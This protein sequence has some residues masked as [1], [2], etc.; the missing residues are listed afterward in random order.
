ELR[1]EPDVP[2][3]DPDHHQGRDG[4]RH[5]VYAGEGRRWRRD[6]KRRSPP[7]FR[8][9]GGQVVLC[10]SS[11]DPPLRHTNATMKQKQCLERLSYFV[12][13]N[14]GSIQPT[15]ELPAPRGARTQQW[16][17]ALVNHISPSWAPLVGRLA[18]LESSP[19]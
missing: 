2:E 1:P 4:N 6:L 7:G 17:S 10:K 13:K 14:Q 12:R 16:P 3:L 18:A 11:P 15:V 5:L 9:P 8:G 19:M